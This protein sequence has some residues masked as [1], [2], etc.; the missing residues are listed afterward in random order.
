MYYKFNF[1]EQEKCKGLIK[2]L[3]V[4]WGNKIKAVSTFEKVENE[5][6]AI[7]F[8]LENKIV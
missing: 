6:E 3:V 8:E 5:Y 4:E 7:L 1:A 2:S